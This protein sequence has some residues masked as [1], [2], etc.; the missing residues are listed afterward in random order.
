MNKVLL[1]AK[2][3]LGSGQLADRKGER[4]GSGQ[5]AQRFYSF[6]TVARISLAG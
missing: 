2:E 6:T 5:L 1:K 3:R 4:L